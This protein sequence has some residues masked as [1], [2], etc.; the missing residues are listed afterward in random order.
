MSHQQEPIV[1]PYEEGDELV[2]TDEHPFCADS[3]CGCHEDDLLI[4]EVA[5]RVASGELTPQQA[6]DLVAGKGR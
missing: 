3:T 2:H 1:I 5:S 4:S 6:T